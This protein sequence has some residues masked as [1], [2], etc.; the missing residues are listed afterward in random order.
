MSNAKFRITNAAPKPPPNLHRVGGCGYGDI[1]VRNNDPFLV[2]S[3][4][5]PFD[6]VRLVPLW[7]GWGA[8]PDNV[9]YDTMVERLGK[10]E[11]HTAADFRAAAAN[12]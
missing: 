5:P 1:V 6:G 7:G 8:S 3:A 10:L 2:V 4:D 12:A 11:G 9:S